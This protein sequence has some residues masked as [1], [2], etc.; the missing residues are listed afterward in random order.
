[1]ARPIGSD[2]NAIHIHCLVEI[3]HFGALNRGLQITL[4]VQA[5]ACSSKKA[6]AGSRQRWTAGLYN[7][8]GAETQSRTKQQVGP[9]ITCIADRS[10]D[11]EVKSNT[12]GN[13]IIQAFDARSYASKPCG[14]GAAGKG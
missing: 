3:H 12:G 9:M 13:R 11:A 14:D 8:P 1:M 7:L 5:F 4:S 2:A 6:E 10:T